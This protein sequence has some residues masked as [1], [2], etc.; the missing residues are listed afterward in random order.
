MKNPKVRIEKFDG[1]D[2]GFWKMHIEDYLYQ[3]N[4]HEPLSGEKAKTM[5]QEIQDLKDRKTLG[6][7][8][9][10]L[11]RNVTF[12]IV[13]ETMTVGLLEALA[14]M[15]EKS[16]AINKLD[17]MSYKIVFKESS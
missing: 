2:F 8:R 9:L 17:S 1:T 14:N 15:Y 5:K 7:I 12:N 6:L 3:N 13:K 16:L 11:V 10:T 4:L